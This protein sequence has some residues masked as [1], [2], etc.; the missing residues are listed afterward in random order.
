M[1]LLLTLALVVAQAQ[2]PAPPAPVLNA[3]TPGGAARFVG[4]TVVAVDVYS[5][6]LPSSDATVAGLIET[7]AG[8]PLSM[9]AVRETINHIHSL[10]RYQ[11]VSIDATDVEG[12]VRLRYDLVP[13]QT[14]TEIDFRGDLGLD[15][16]DLRRV[17]TD[18]FGSAP[19]ASR[20]AAAAELLQRY[21]FE[22]GY[23]G[24]AIRPT[25]EPGARPEN[26]VL[27]FDV[28]SGERARIRDVKVNGDPGEPTAT[29]LQKIRAN[30]GRVYQLVE[31]EERLAQYVQELR[32][33]GHYEANGTHRMAARSDDGQSVDLEVG[34][35]L[36][37][38]IVVRFEGDPLPAN[39]LD[40]LVPVERE[41]SVDVDIIE[42]SEHRIV[43]Y[44]NQQG[45]WK[46]AVKS[47]R[48]ERENGIE[49]VFTV[50]RGLRYRIDGGVEVTGNPSV[51]L[52]DVRRQVNAFDDVLR[53]L[54]DGDL[55]VRANLDAAAAALAG[56]YMQRGFAQVKVE[57]TVQEL[58]S[59]ADQG[60]VK[61]GIAVVEGPRLTVG[62]VSFTGNAAVPTPELSRLQEL[63]PGA[64]YYEP[65]VRRA[66]EAIVREYLNRGFPFAAVEARTRA[67]NNRVA[68]EFAIS[69]GTQTFIDH[70]LIVGNVN[71][72]TEVIEREL[73][74]ESLRP[75]EPLGLDSL[76]NVRRRLGELGLFRSVRITEIPHGDSGRRDLLITVEESPATSVGYGAGVEL[77]SR[78]ETDQ[79]GNRTTSQLELAPRGFFEIG[80]RNLGGKN[81]S[82]SLYTRVSL[83]SD[84]EPGGSDLFGFADYRVIATYREPKTFGWDAE[85]R[86]SGALEQGVRSA[87]SFTRKGVT[88]DVLRRFT[89]TFY[90]SARYTFSSTR[91]FDLI[92]DEDEDDGEEL[93]T[94]DRVFPR[95]RLSAFSG[96]F[97]RDT[98]DDQI[99]PTRGLFVTAESTLAARS[100]GGEVGFVKTYLEGNAY[101][102]LTRSGSVVLAGRLAFGLADGFPRQ[103]D[104][105]GPDGQP[106]VIDDLP[107]S[108]RFFAGGDTTVRGFDLDSLGTAETLTA[109]GV[110]RGG[111]GL[112]LANLELRVPIRGNFRGAVFVDGGNVFDRVSSM[113]A[114]G[115]R[116]AVGFGLRYRTPVGPLRVDV[117][118]KLDPQ[119]FRGVREDR[120]VFHFS[121]GHAF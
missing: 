75:G 32:R 16:G 57:S 70:V 85:V 64:P 104:V 28:R 21:Y 107:A 88:A 106:L 61:P 120:R 111:N 89:P 11:E 78:F 116:G 13:I 76:F 36:G 33:D 31:V 83:R 72:R 109:G 9:S 119:E 45:Y 95:V 17:V 71:I 43:E 92:F 105:P 19:P 55:F 12:G 77:N 68:V 94:I 114:G 67:E 59:A 1:I 15:K 79:A 121:F 24:A 51:L 49:I 103:T 118:F 30:R 69:E 82:A 40:D 81:R 87:F 100:L 73:N 2:P 108:E 5:G 93:L 58:P 27:T 39:R 18:R 42:D 20:A 110:P 98:R 84:N 91:V 115:L 60:R 6:G 7:P 97:A 80:R 52:A 63:T 56:I 102:R 113:D 3:Q 112:V 8:A 50:N 22:H 48:V 66:R 29:F 23:L 96:S 41:G 25:L 14:V 99:E 34:I 65:N 10:G 37:P 53:T 86:I 4:R 38:D 117:G 101:R 54:E 35:N 44:L 26:A 90:G 46:A 74:A 62:Q 47:T